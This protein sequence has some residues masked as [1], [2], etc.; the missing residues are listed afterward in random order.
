V[1][2]YDAAVHTRAPAVVAALAVA[3]LGS[4]CITGA[5]IAKPNNVK[6]PVLIGA[7]AAD[8][9]VVILIAS[10]L[11]SFSSEGAVFTGVAVTGADI[12]VGCILGACK[13]LNP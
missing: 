12:A 3:M 8:L 13:S 11:D 5:A 10:Q 1:H 4:G 6:L 7:V 2:G 9:L